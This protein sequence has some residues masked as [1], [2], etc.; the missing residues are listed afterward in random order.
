LSYA[1][2][3]LEVDGKPF[4]V[5]EVNW[6]PEDQPDHS[7][8][9]YSQELIIQAETYH[10]HRLRKNRRPVLDYSTISVILSALLLPPVG[11][12]NPV[13]GPAEPG[14][15]E[16]ASSGLHRGIVFPD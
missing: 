15:C 7:I 10:E 6:I 12:I 11:Q 3:A 13:C 16:R 1:D 2:F 5:I 4:L 14:A 8:D 9:P